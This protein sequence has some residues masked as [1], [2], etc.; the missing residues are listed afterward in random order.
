MH[1]REINELM[2]WNTWWLNG[3]R[4]RWFWGGME[5]RLFGW[6]I[7]GLFWTN[8]IFQNE[9]ENFKCNAFKNGRLS[10]N[11]T[12]FMVN[13]QIYKKKS[14]DISLADTKNQ[15]RTFLHSKVSIFFCWIL[16]EAKQKTTITNEQALCN[17]RRLWRM[18][19][20]P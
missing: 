15:S 8:I 3:W 17:K 10:N 2:S 1:A 7:C 4:D 9:I 16:P 19:N 5:W 18:S 12:H 11:F 6:F 13:V 20:R 14:T